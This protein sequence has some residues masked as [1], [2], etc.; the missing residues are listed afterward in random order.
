[1]L[2]NIRNL[3]PSLS[4]STYIILL[5]NDVR[6]H[7]DGLRDRILHPKKRTHKNPSSARISRSHESPRNF[8]LFADGQS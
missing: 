5:Y 7:L 4:K 2:L 6:I 8:E 1:M 3:G